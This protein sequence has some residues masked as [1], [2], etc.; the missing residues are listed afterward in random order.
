VNLFEEEAQLA[1]QETDVFTYR[2]AAAAVA[3]TADG[4]A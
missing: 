3:A 4:E 2:S 1:V